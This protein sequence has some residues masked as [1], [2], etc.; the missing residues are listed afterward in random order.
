MGSACVSC[1]SHPFQGHDAPNSSLPGL[2]QS[3]SLQVLA[4]KKP[5]V[6][7]LMGNDCNGIDELIGGAAAIVRGFYPATHGARALASLL[8]G[9]VSGWDCN[10]GQQPWTTLDCNLGQL[11]S[12]LPSSHTGPGLASRGTQARPTAGASSR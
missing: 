7:L 2:Q 9:A 6:L 1:A 8:F 4:K 11:F 12:C 10:L 3:F 5:T